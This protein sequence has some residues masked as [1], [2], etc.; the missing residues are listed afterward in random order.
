MTEV[1]TLLRKLCLSFGRRER[2]LKL[3]HLIA[4]HDGKLIFSFIDNESRK[5]TLMI[6]LCDQLSE[7]FSLNW[8]PGIVMGFE[9]HVADYFSNKFILLLKTANQSPKT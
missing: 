8:A 9:K 3:S 5:A 6:V 1:L 2:P 4:K 7:F